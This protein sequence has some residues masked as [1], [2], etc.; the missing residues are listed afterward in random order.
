MCNFFNTLEL[1]NRDGAT[2]GRVTAQVACDVKLTGLL[3]AVSRLP[4][5]STSRNKVLT[6][7]NGTS[8]AAG[9]GEV[10][11]WRGGDVVEARADAI[12]NNLAEAV[13]L[14]ELCALVN[15]PSGASA[16][17]SDLKY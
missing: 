16:G 12:L 10:K 11:T 7:G 4:G 14:T 3:I 2:S 13:L 6:T 5:N 8:S 9:S 15:K 17:A 1:F